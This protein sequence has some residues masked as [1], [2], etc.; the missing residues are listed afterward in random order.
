MRANMNAARNSRTL[1]DDGADALS[2][3]PR[4]GHRVRFELI[5]AS[6]WLVI[7]LFA[8]PGVIFWVGTSAFGAYGENATLSTFYGD[9]Y[10]DLADGSGR[11][12]VLA[13]GP[14]VLIYLIRAVFIGMKPA[15]ARE[16]VEVDE[17]PP[18]RR[19]PAKKEP[20]KRAATRPARVEPRMGG[21]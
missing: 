13:L 11:A 4:P 1:A 16:D 3:D 12:W 5:F 21:D 6:L 20:A 15:A 14:V 7:G 19:A 9:F 10:G 8:L 17:A 18:P 2:D